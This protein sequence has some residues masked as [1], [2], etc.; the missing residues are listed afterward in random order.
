MKVLIL[1]WWIGTRFWP[2]SRKYYPKQFVQLQQFD[3][4]SFFQ[5]TLKRA[6][7]IT[8]NKDIFVLTN[9]DYKF[10]CINQ[11]KEIGF[12][13]SDEQIILEPCPKNTLWAISLWM[14]NLADNDIALVLASD[15]IIWDDN[16]FADE[17]KSVADEAAKHIVIFGIK[18]TSPNTWYGYIQSEKPKMD[19]SRVLNFKEKPDAKTAQK[20]IKKSFLWNSWIFLFS[21]KIFSEELKKSNKKYYDLTKKW[22]LKNFDLLPNLSIDYWIMEKSN[23]IYMKRLDTYWNDLGSWD[24]FAEYFDFKNADV[25]EIQWKNN[26]AVSDSTSKKIIFLWTEDLIAVDTKDSLLISKVWHTQMVKNVVDSLSQT[27]KQFVEFGKTVYRP[28]WNYT[29]IDEW[30]WFKTKRISV[31]PGSKLSLQMHYHRSEHWVVVSGTATVTVWDQTKILRK[32]ESVYIPSWTIHRLEN[33][34]KV[35]LHI[36]ESQIWDY[37]EEDDIVRFDDDFGRI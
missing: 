35:I 19:F 20:Y 21:K 14:E 8:N 18:P 10:H 9:I 27:D 22:V 31:L 3:N 5:Q 28:W 1:A 6:L 15:H 12:S 37:L 36:I 32:G 29:I 24:S 17:V 11:A 23:N 2:V 26:F 34:W 33:A 7:K 30:S 16:K 13:F 25:L 4:I